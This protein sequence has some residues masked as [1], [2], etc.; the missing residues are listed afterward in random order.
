[1]LGYKREHVSDE[2]HTIPYILS[3]SP[4][5]ALYASCRKL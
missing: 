1:M 5:T 4:C 3:S 2:A